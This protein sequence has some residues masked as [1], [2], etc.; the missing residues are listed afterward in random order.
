MGR[1]CCKNGDIRRVL[2]GKPE[3][4]WQLGRPICNW[5]HNI[6]NGLTE[7]R[8]GNGLYSRSSELLPV[9]GSCEKDHENYHL[10]GDDTV[11]L[12]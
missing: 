1:A 8:W 10:L 11:W 2:G 6:K 3:G 9:A 7:I 4:K 5:E 12:L